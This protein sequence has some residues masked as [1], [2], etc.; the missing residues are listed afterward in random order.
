MKISGIGYSILVFSLFLHAFI[1]F[2]ASDNYNGSPFTFIT[3]SLLSSILF[4]SIFFKHQ[5][6]F[7]IFITGYIWLG[8]YVKY[9]ISLALM[10]PI[11]WES[12][13]LTLDWQNIDPLLNKFNYVIILIIIVNILSSFSKQNLEFKDRFEIQIHNTRFYSVFFGFLSL[14]VFVS[15]IN[16]SFGFYQRGLVSNAS[17]PLGLEKIVPLCVLIIFPT[18]AATLCEINFRSNVSKF[19]TLFSLIYIIEAFFSNLSILSRAGFL[20]VGILSVSLYKCRSYLKHSFTKNNWFNILIYFSVFLICCFISVQVVN[21]VRVVLFSSGNSQTLG[22]EIFSDLNQPVVRTAQSNMLLSLVVDRWVGI[23][24]WVAAY[25]SGV[26]GF[27][28][29]SHFWHDKLSSNS[30][31]TYDREIINSP[32]RYLLEFPDRTGVSLP[33]IMGFLAVSGSTPFVLVG[34][35]IMFIIGHALERAVSFIVCGSPFVCAV[36]MHLIAYRFAQFGYVPSRSYILI[37][38]VF[39]GAVIARLLMTFIRKKT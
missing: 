21:A 14:L 18:I 35:I 39:I 23:E 15:L 8:F 2:F 20:Q 22:V 10:R 34:V 19:P 1:L 6:F 12:K 4:S 5:L 11:F 32:Y 26:Q 36:L 16:L 37:V 33:G 27:D 7:N 17:L 30:L 3:F 25:T 29:W 31:G 9:S 24:G 13:D 38:S 28:T